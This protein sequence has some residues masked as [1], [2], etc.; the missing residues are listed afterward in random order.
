MYAWNNR[1][2]I[3]NHICHVINLWIKQFIYNCIYTKPQVDHLGPIEEGIL[4]IPEK[5][6]IATKVRLEPRCRW[7][8]EA[9]IEINYS[10]RS[11]YAMLRYYRPA[12]THFFDALASLEPT[13]DYLC[14]RTL[15]QTGITASEGQIWIKGDRNS[16]LFRP[17]PRTSLTCALLASFFLDASAS[18]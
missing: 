4:Q 18:L 9:E 6:S 8:E 11:S 12:A 14:R 17:L 10:A 13:S 7:W 3:M 15:T 2:W 5:P 1:T 16:R